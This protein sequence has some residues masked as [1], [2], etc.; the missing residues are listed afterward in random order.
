VGDGAAI[1]DPIG[2]GQ[3]PDIAGGTH[4]RRWHG[5]RWTGSAP[6]EQVGRRRS[7]RRRLGREP[8]VVRILRMTTGSS[9]V[10][11]TRMRP[12]HRAH[13][14]TST[15]NVCC[16]NSGQLLATPGYELAI[17]VAIL[18][19]TDDRSGGTPHEPTWIATYAPETVRCFLNHPTLEPAITTGNQNL[20]A[21]ALNA[22]RLPVPAPITSDAIDQLFR[23]SGRD[24]KGEFGFALAATIREAL[25]KGSTLVIPDH[26]DA[27]FDYLYPADEAGDGTADATPPSH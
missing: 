18:R 7:G 6:V 17:R 1:G 5:H 15:P 16:I 9:M 19:D 13:A 11:T 23:T 10:A 12:P 4:P 20:V 24:R 2:G 22:V 26:I 25:G 8:E 21:D 27:L 14:N 3:A